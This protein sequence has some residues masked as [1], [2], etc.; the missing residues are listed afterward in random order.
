[1]IDNTRPA[2][3]ILSPNGFFGPDDHL[4]AEGEK[5]YFDGEP[6]E[7]M[8]PLNELAHQKLTEALEK[9]DNLARDAATK[10]CRPF[11]GRPRSFDGA[12]EL[13]TELARSN[14]AIMGAKRDVRPVERIDSDDVPETGSINPKQRGRGRPR[15]DSIAA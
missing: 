4:W 2:Y 7:E 12:L 13:A 11:V 8:E 9:L 1:M 14:V 3:R 5:L 10:L 15:K 6:N